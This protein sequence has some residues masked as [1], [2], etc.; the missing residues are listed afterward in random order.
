[1][2]DSLVMLFEEVC[3]LSWTVPVESNVSKVPQTYAV[4]ERLTSPSL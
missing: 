3:R 2:S 1:M 4:P